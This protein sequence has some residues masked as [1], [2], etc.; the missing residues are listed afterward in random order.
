M[1]PLSRRNAQPT[2]EA[3]PLYI[4]HDGVQLQVFAPTDV[5]LTKEDLAAQLRGTK[6]YLIR[7]VDFLH[8]PHTRNLTL[9]KFVDLAENQFSLAAHLCNAVVLPHTLGVVALNENLDT[10][11]LLGERRL[12]HPCLPR[13]HALAMKV[14]KLSS[15][16]RPSPLDKQ[17]YTAIQEGL[18]IYPQIVNELIGWSDASVN[19]FLVVRRRAFIRDTRAAKLPR[20]TKLPKGRQ[21]SVLSDLD[22]IFSMIQQA[23]PKRH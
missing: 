21:L 5:A 22:W 20:P 19:Q 12:Y 16:E 2:P 1:T 8:D 17:E 13:G 10:E 4:E 15:A 9:G 23:K 7:R 6:P 3:L 11:W 18:Q 14:P